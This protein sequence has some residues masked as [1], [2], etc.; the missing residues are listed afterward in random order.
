M[1]EGRGIEDKVCRSWGQIAHGLAGHSK[2]WSLPGF[3][4]EIYY[5]ME[6]LFSRQVRFKEERSG[7]IVR[8]CDG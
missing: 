7:R 6:L 3:T 4:V 5:R 8:E 2:A 1:G